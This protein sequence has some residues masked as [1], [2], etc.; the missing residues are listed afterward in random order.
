MFTIENLIDSNDRAYMMRGNNIRFVV[1]L[2]LESQQSL[3][4]RLRL[5]PW[6]LEPGLGLNG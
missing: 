1:Q 6:S 3:A 2:C 5:A 4:L